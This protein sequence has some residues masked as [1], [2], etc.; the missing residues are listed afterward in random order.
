MSEIMDRCRPGGRIVMALKGHEMLRMP[1]HLQCLHNG[2]QSTGP[3][4]MLRTSMMLEVIGMIDE[5]DVHNVLLE[6]SGH[7]TI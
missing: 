3:F 1:T 4:R 6:Q 5:A 7:T 2:F